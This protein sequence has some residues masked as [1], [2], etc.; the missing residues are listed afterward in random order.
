[1]DPMMDPYAIAI[2]EARDN[3]IELKVS[4]PEPKRKLSECFEILQQAV[5]G[6]RTQLREGDLVRFIPSG[7][8]ANFIAAQ[9]AHLWEVLNV[10][11]SE[12]ESPVPLTINLNHATKPDDR[13][14][15]TNINIKDFFLAH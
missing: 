15:L 5:D 11:Y 1:M 10:G 8:T 13:H 2:S 3:Q 12:G 14:A 9:P 7:S 4:P 6:S